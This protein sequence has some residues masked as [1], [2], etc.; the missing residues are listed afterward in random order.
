M[1]SSPPAVQG[2][3]PMQRGHTQEGVRKNWEALGQQVATW[4]AAKKPEH[5]L[6]QQSPHEAMKSRQAQIT[7]PR[8][9]PADE[10]PRRS[11]A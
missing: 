10:Q 8:A 1:Q 9:P 7:V 2:Q 3:T 6:G 5:S 4:D 11:K